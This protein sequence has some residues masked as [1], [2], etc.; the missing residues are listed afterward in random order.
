MVLRPDGSKG[1][2]FYQG[3]KINEILSQGQ[4]TNN[5]QVVF[6]A[7][8]NKE[9]GNIIAINYNRPL[10]SERNLTS[11]IKGDFKSV[12][13]MKL[14]KLLTTY[15]S[16]VNETYALY[17]FDVAKKTLDKAIY[18]DKNYNVLEAFLVNTHERPKK[19][20][21]EVN[22]NVKTG[23]LLCQDIN[24]TEGHFVGNTKLSSKAVKIELLGINNSLG[25]V[26]VEKDGSFYLKVLVRIPH[27][28][29]KQL[30]KM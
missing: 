1:E 24:F 21:S 10:H 27:S 2:L 6:I 3:E 30:I 14:K 11:G 26:G 20:P 7:A 23:L 22:L 28:E 29:F 8:N 4:E 12:S 17:E 19:L 16:S 13:P 15:R 18:K 5:G 25:T 9:R